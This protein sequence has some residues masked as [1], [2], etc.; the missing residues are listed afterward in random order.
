MSRLRFGLRLKL[1]FFSSFLLAIPWLG[2]Q[3][4]WEM[5]TYLRIGQEQ[6]MVGTARAVATALHE[7]PALFDSQ[8]AYLTDVKPGTD[9]YA[10]KIA[11]P[12]QLDGKLDDWQ[13]YRHLSIAYGQQN[14]IDPIQDYDLDSL[15]FKHMV[16]QYNRFLYAMFDV[17]DDNV[18]LRPKNSLRVDKNDHL[19]IAM[20][21]QTGLF[22]RYIIAPSQPGWV[23]AY[24]LEDDLESLQPARLETKIQGQW[25]NTSK[26][27]QLELRFPLAMMSSKIAFAIVD[28]DD[29]RTRAVEHIMGTANPSQV[30]SLGTVLVPSPEIEKI[31]KGLKYSNARVWV[32]DKHRRVLARSGNIQRATGVQSESKLASS[33]DAQTQSSN[34][35]W[36]YIEQNW[37]L[38]LYYQILTKPPAD[39]VDDLRDAFAL[40][41]QDISQAL[42]G[43]PSSLWRL[44][45]DNKAVIMSAAHPIYID[46]TVMGAVVVEQTTNG[47]RTLRNKALERQFHYILLVILI[48]TLALFL[49]ASRISWRIRKLRNETEDAIDQQGKIIGNILPS[50]TRDEIGD[51]SRTFTHVLSRLSQYNTYLENM[52]SRLSHELRTPVA[53]VNSSLD[54]LL[55]E[56]HSTESKQYVDRAKHGIT[57]LSKILSNMSE[58]TR[59]EQA[60]QSNDRETFDLE[61]LLRGCV[62]GY[63]IA[64]ATRQFDVQ[65]AVSNATFQ[66]SPELFAQMLDKIIANGVEFSDESTAIEL[67]MVNSDNGYV[68]TIANQG[69]SLPD[70]MQHQLFDSMVSVRKQQNTAQPHLGLGLYIAKIIA[71]YHQG[72]IRIDNLKDKAGVVVTLEFKV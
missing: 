27:Y 19:Q 26:G 24:L 16:G 33:N 45:S 58:A 35:W 64:Y 23:N 7:R 51:L 11:Y 29:P 20:T 69:P 14:L 57:R 31:L 6:T 46:E 59:L 1:L 53:I 38:P 63:R 68:V 65:I 40:Q 66:G 44:S 61:E 2:Y 30:D 42:S 47:I 60:I 34:S 52:A 67:Q 49:I 3:Y 48:S 50:N 55:L 25:R 8:S 13:E 62:A 37:L 28:V 15:H 41:G 72:T 10:H 71:Q 21:D 12:I 70:N 18:L 36:K 54:N 4:V 32:V 43:T 5:E 17:T 22:Q 56:E 39:F 9:L